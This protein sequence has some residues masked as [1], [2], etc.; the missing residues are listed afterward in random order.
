MFLLIFSFL[1]LCYPWEVIMV[2][3]MNIN[4]KK[5]F[6]TVCHEVSG[7]RRI[8]NGAY[9]HSLECYSESNMSN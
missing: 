4:V 1:S 7:S 9:V 2:H 3:P 8:T 5:S 6:I